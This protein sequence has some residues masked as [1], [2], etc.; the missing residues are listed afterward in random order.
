MFYTAIFICGSLSFA[1]TM[2]LDSRTVRQKS[3][4]SPKVV[5]K[6]SEQ[7]VQVYTCVYMMLNSF[8]VFVH[9]SFTRYQLSQLARIAWNRIFI[10]HKDRS[11]SRIS[12]DNWNH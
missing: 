12:L 9:A 1:S 11:I 5:E 4:P 8:V 10:E 7:S 2:F 6:N 3:N